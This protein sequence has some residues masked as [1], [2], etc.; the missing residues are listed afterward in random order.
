MRK[1]ALQKIS[2]PAWIA[3]LLVFML[4]MALTTGIAFA[5]PG[6]QEDVPAGDETVKQCAECHL[7]IADSWSISPHAHAY[8]DPYFQERWEGLGSPDECLSCHTTNFIASTGEYSDEGVHC[9]A[10]H[11]TATSEHP[12]EVIPIQADTEYCGKCHTTTLSEWKTTAHSPAGVGCMQCHDP[13]SQDSLFEVKDDL[14]IN[15][16][17]EDMERYL[18]DMHVQKGIGCVDCHALVIPPEEIPD[19]GIVPTGHAFNIT[20]ATCVACHTDA[21]HAGFSL[22][23]YEHGAAAYTE[24]NGITETLTTETY[25]AEAVAEVETLT[26]EQQ[27]Q[28]LE[29]ALASRN[30][31]TLF[32]GAIVGVVLGGSTAWIVARNVRRAPVD[33]NEEEAN[34]EENE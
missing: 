33:E 26:P 14:C 11:G 23:G 3:G 13:H 15:C 4:V 31:T 7:D 6:T 20:P 19:D 27:V 18:E 12:P 25:Q 22:P 29:A 32:Q 34:G 16:H 17:Q 8:D 9:E 30:I 21:L 2:T 28:T 10:C 5:A 24:A 1:K